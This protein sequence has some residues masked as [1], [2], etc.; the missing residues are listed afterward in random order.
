MIDISDGLSSDLNRICQQSQV[1]AIIDAEKIPV[2]NDA[3]NTENPLDSALN[4]G[5]DFELLFTVSQADCQR[6]LDEWNEPIIITQIGTITDNRKM[7]IKMPNG[8]ISDLLPRGYE[9]LQS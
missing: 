9:H 7:Q 1:G 3:E 6:L 8:Q 5:E 2:S 4:D